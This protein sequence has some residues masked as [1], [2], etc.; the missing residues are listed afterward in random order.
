[1]NVYLSG[2]IGVGKSTVG[3]AI[4]GMLGW[5]FDDLDLA[6]ERMAGKNFRQV[7]ADEGW[8]G[9]RMREYSLCKQFA[10]MKNTVIG[11]GGGTVRYE[12][13]R[14][15]LKGYGVNILLTAN[16]S[17]LANR[18][19]NNDRPR[20]NPNASMEEDLIWMWE[21]HKDIYVG[22][23]DIVYPTDQGKSVEEESKE[24]VSILRKD[25]SI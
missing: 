6:M 15:V 1:M 14:D 11:L 3:Q 20:V 21:K 10:H 23:A 22:F 9:F 18:I 12:W 25:F 2:L 7:V 8:L 4:A 5:P 17:I 16:L 13:N 24:L 19:S